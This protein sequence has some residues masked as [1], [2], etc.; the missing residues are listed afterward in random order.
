MPTEPHPVAD[1]GADAAS[2]LPAAE[3]YRRL[4]LAGLTAREAGSLVAH[5]AGLEPAITGWR[6]AEIEGLLFVRAM[7]QAGKL[8]S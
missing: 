4:R 8:R 2:Q 3:I 5:L 1:P 6:L 7:V